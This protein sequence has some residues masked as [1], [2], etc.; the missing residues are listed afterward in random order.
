V[1]LQSIHPTLAQLLATMK[2]GQLWHP[3]RIGDWMVVVRLEELVSAQLDAAME[4]RLMDELY[5]NWLQQQVQQSLQ[6]V[7][8]SVST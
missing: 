1:E 2:P 4:Q 5:G 6:P 7:T 8:A 3:V